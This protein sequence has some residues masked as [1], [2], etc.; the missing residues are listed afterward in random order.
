MKELFK[1]LEAVLK[2]LTNKRGDKLFPTV[3][4]NSGQMQKIKGF[5]NSQGI[6]LFPAVFYKPEEIVN[7]TKHNGVYLTQIRIRLHVVTNNLIHNDPLEIFDLPIDVDNAL[8]DNKWISENFISLNKSDEVMPETFDNN[9]I[10]ELNYWMKYWN[11]NSYEYR[12]WIDINDPNE[13]PDYKTPMEII[14]PYG[15][16]DD[17]Y[18]DPSN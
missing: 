13:N 2:S 11:T 6:I 18:V 9:Q 4:L 17:D 5:E 14:Q 15:F 8:L 16:I 3:E 10:Y 12:S 1:E 7:N